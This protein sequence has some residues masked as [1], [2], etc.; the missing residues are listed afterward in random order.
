MTTSVWL[1]AA[2]FL[3]IL[4]D[5]DAK[6]PKNKQ[7]EKP[8]FAEMPDPLDGTRLHPQDYEF[9]RKMAVDALEVDEEDYSDEHP[10]AV[11]TMFMKADERTREK[12]L[13]ALSLDDFAQNL[14][15]TQR[16]KKRMTL[17]LIH[18]ELLHPFIDKRP[19]FVGPDAWEIMT[20]LTSETLKSL[21]RGLI[22]PVQVVRIKQA[23]ALVRLS[24]NMEATLEAYHFVDEGEQP[25][26]I[27]RLVKPGQ[28]V[29]A[30]IS[31]VDPVTFKVQLHA[32][33]SVL[34][35]SDKHLR[36][37]EP[38]PYYDTTSAYRDNLALE[39]RRKQINNQARRVIKHP[40]FHNMRS[41]EAEEYLSKQQRGDVVIRPSSHGSNHLAVT[42]KVDKGIYQHIGQLS[43]ADL[44]C[45]LLTYFNQTFLR[46]Q[47]IPMIPWLDIYT[48][49]DKTGLIPILMS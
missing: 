33:P 16:E 11:V 46:S 5:P 47:S 3:R 25:V 34:Q 9:A 32:R 41:K 21:M 35:A 40:N 37:V 28:V 2:A 38:D 14:L 36:N 12:Q 48:A 18:E 10:S 7:G 6:Q 13:K 27:E 39:R 20:M 15:T 43:W 19:P 49:S 8:N 29:N 4:Q 31:E 22:V 30:V 17:D 26:P 44:P 42:W 24:S 45:K 23:A 1:N